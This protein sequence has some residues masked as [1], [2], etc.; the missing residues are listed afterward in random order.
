MTPCA[1]FSVCLLLLHVGAR[2]N[3]FKI[4]F[5]FCIQYVDSHVTFVFFFR[6][7]LVL[8]ERSAIIARI[9]WFLLRFP[10][11][12]SKGITMLL[13]ACLFF[14]LLLDQT[15]FFFF[16]TFTQPALS[17]IQGDAFLTVLNFPGFPLF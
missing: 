12:K 8:P 7:S 4:N 16:C 5:V 15:L 2:K 1:F 14:I 11:R 13:R 17:D 6:Y 10:L 9:L 3:S